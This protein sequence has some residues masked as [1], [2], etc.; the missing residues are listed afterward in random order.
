MYFVKSLILDITWGILWFLYPLLNHCQIRDLVLWITTKLYSPSNQSLIEDFLVKGRSGQL[1]SRPIFL[2]TGTWFE[3]RTIIQRA[4]FY[5]LYP[6]SH[7][8]PPSSFKP[9]PV[10][11]SYMN[12]HDDAVADAC[13]MSDD[14]RVCDMNWESK[15]R[16]ANKL[17]R[18]L[19]HVS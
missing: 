13:F 11:G 10:L 8:I 2:G 1:L 14:W 3:Y 19:G 18:K 17:A 12:F 5:K 16:A 7:Y 4:V 15:K 9:H 6:D